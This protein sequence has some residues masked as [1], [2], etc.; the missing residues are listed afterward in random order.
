MGAIG[1]KRGGDHREKGAIV[2]KEGNDRHRREVIG[3]QKRAIV[4]T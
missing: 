1:A 3:A 2:G 4:R